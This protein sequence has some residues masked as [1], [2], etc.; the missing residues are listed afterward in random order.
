MLIEWHIIDGKA[1][2]YTLHKQCCD[3]WN[4]NFEN[5]I[6]YQPYGLFLEVP[7]R[8]DIIFTEPYHGADAE[9]EPLI[10]WQ[11]IGKIKWCP[12]CGARISM[13]KTVVK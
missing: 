8:M 2:A 12:F 1:E 4:D 9:D 3:K 11:R 6:N 13:Y 7:T 5:Y 10:H